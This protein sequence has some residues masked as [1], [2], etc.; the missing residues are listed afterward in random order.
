MKQAFS[1]QSRQPDW[2]S[3]LLSDC[4]RCRGLFVTWVPIGWLGYSWLRRGLMTQAR[5]LNLPLGLRPWCEPNRNR[6]PERTVMFA[7]PPFEESFWLHT[8]LPSWCKPLQNQTCELQYCFWCSNTSRTT[9]KCA[10]SHAFSTFIGTASVWCRHVATSAL[11]VEDA[12][13]ATAVRRLFWP[14]FTQIASE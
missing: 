8:L 9:T 5:R 12:L 1:A 2:R 14:P 11:G 3:N 6:L 7:P 13:Q 10:C 4:W